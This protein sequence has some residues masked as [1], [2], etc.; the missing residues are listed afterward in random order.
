[1]LSG[2][3]QT[4]PILSQTAEGAGVEGSLTAQSTDTAVLTQQATGA[5]PKIIRGGT[6]IGRGRGS[7]GA[8]PTLNDNSIIRNIVWDFDDEIRL[9]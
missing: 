8:T 2:D 1:M 7:R 9:F 3:M 4:E 6:P 5:I